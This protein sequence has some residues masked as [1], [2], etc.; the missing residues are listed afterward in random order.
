MDKMVSKNGVLKFSFIKKGESH[1]VVELQEVS[2]DRLVFLAPFLIDI[3][4]LKTGPNFK[5]ECKFKTTVELVCDRCLINYSYNINEEKNFFIGNVD[6]NDV[7]EFN[8]RDFKG[9]IDIVN[10]LEEEIIMDLPP[11]KICK[12]SCEG[13]CDSCGGN[14]NIEKCKCN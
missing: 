2:S 5:F 14:L 8:I 1:L 3:K 11:Q 9:E 12:P 10:F 6:T 13:L 7:N 4:L